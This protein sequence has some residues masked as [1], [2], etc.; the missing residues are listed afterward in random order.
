MEEIRFTNRITGEHVLMALFDPRTG[1][2]HIQLDY[3]EHRMWS[4]D[5]YNLQDDLMHELARRGCRVIQ[6]S[7]IN[8]PGIQNTKYDVPFDRWYGRP[9]VNYGFGSGVQYP[10]SS[11]SMRKAPALA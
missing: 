9:T 10:L 3:N 11:A 6:I 4:N 2:A 8:R 7:E 5:T 1:V